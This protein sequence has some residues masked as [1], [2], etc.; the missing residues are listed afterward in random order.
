V[1][2]MCTLQTDKPTEPSCPIPSIPAEQLAFWP[3]L[4]LVN[5]SFYYATFWLRHLCFCVRLFSVFET[6]LTGNQVW[7]DLSLSLN[8]QQYFR[9]PFSTLAYK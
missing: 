2:E 8:P 5:I 7:I 3:L 4:L 9:S 6:C 1:A